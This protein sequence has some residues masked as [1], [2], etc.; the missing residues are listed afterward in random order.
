MRIQI[1]IKDLHLKDLLYGNK[2]RWLIKKNGIVTVR[3]ENGDELSLM[4]TET[5]TIERPDNK[6]EK[7]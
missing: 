6:K 4:E 2:I 5:V 3:F 1:Q 7:P